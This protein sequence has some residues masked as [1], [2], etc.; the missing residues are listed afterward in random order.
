MA[1]I[2]LQRNHQGIQSLDFQLDS[3]TEHE[4]A[5]HHYGIGGQGDIIKHSNGVLYC[6]LAKTY[7]YGQLAP[8][9]KY[10]YMGYST[11]DGLTW[12]D[13]TYP[14]QQPL[15]NMDTY[16]IEW[17]WCDEPRLLQLIPDDV[18]SPIGLIFT[19]SVAPLAD[20]SDT[21]VA[22]YLYRAVVEVETDGS[23][24]LVP[25]AP[26][27]VEFITGSSIN[28]RSLSLLRTG[29]SWMITAVNSENNLEIYDKDIT[30]DADSLYGFTNNAWA[31]RTIAAPAGSGITLEC[32]N[33]RQLSDNR[34]LV[35][36]NARTAVNGSAT[37]GG[38]LRHD[39]F[40]AVSTN[41]LTSLGTPQQLTS[42]SNYLGVDLA[43]GPLG[44]G[45]GDVA[46][47]SDGK[48]AVC[49]PERKEIQLLSTYTTPAITIGYIKQILYHA[50][51]NMLFIMG[52]YLSGET[53]GLWVVD[54]TNST[55]T[56]IT[57]SSTPSLWSEVIQSIAL[58]DDGNYLAVGEDTALEII[59]ISSATISNWTITSLRPSGSVIRN[60]DITWV[61]F[62]GNNLYFTYGTASGLTACYGGFIDVTD[63]AGGVTDLMADIYWSGTYS[64]CVVAAD[65]N[66]LI[67]PDQ[68]VILAPATAGGLICTNLT[69]GAGIDHYGTT[70]GAC[71][72]AVAYD[73]IKNMILIGV[74]AL[75]IRRL[76]PTITEG[77]M[78]ELDSMTLTYLSKVS[79]AAG[80]DAP[81]YFNQ[82]GDAGVYWVESG[83]ASTRVIWWYPFEAAEIIHDEYGGVYEANADA[84]VKGPL[85]VGNRVRGELDLKLGIW[86]R[87]Y[88]T[89]WLMGAQ[90]NGLTNARIVSA[91]YTGRLRW[92][93]FTYDSETNQLVTS[94]VDFYDACN[95]VKIGSPGQCVAS[96][97]MVSDTADKLF[98]IGQY[99]NY[100]AA[101]PFGN[102]FA[103]L[104]PDS[105][106]LQMKMRIKGTNYQQTPTA[107]RIQNTYTNTFDARARLVFAQCIK[108]KA[109]IVP[110]TL[111]LMTIK[112]AIK[113]SKSANLPC[114]FNVQKDMS[115]ELRLRF[116]VDTGYT[117]TATVRSRACISARYSTRIVGH[118]IIPM[119]P[120]TGALVTSMIHRSGRTLGARG[121]I[122]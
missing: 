39:L 104:E 109:K 40:V 82:I 98:F 84:F 91:N 4:E 69:T 108:A 87:T 92:G 35:V 50:G 1:I 61:G 74:S 34:I 55:V 60:G 80:P 6:V 31:K 112:A 28:L 65:K 101:T 119:A 63:I 22:A 23:F 83:Y 44:A 111:K 51:H 16:P 68:N 2:D 75:G 76:K 48:L 88:G 85:Y 24:N 54:L 72:G 70:S 41:N 12:H 105:K 29:T 106:K 116:T 21:P 17:D 32:L 99:R 114:L 25:E 56:E 38:T 30:A 64:S 118:F 66:V 113:G 81:V 79:G 93:A 90:G 10:L 117:G 27:Y 94:G 5:S 52:A 103:I 46:E 95:M 37:Y 89:E 11:D 3:R 7:T 97:R 59:D 53:Y 77:Q 49:Y 14:L 78:V 19:R 9:K 20:N 42:Y 67:L 110:R 15:I 122:G 86:W 33:T 45:V 57:T 73:P 43:A 18:T 36:M 102:I 115:T 47:L 120:T 26:Y 96:F 58:S 13:Y 121:R 100:T 107:A 8:M 71:N 62:N